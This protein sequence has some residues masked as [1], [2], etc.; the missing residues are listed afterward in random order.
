MIPH[1]SLSQADRSS[2]RR[3]RESGVAHGLSTWHEK[4]HSGATCWYRLRTR[5][6]FVL[7]PAAAAAAANLSARSVK[8]VGSLNRYRVPT[9]KLSSW[10]SCPYYN[11]QNLL[12]FFLKIWL[13]F[14]PEINISTFWTMISRTFM[15]KSNVTAFCNCGRDFKDTRTRVVSFVDSY[16]KF[17]SQMLAAVLW[18]HDQLRFAFPFPLQEYRVQSFVFGATSFVNLTEIM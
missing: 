14:V 16:H 11:G 13:F 7:Q 17:R 9:N 8:G 1:S 4:H 5:C 2:L 6:L 12:Y 10:Y 3:R 18:S 15:S